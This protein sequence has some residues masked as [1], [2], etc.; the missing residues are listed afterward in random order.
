MNS[1]HILFKILWN[2]HLSNRKNLKNTLELLSQIK[3]DSIFKEFY[4]FHSIKSTQDLALKIIKRKK[5]ISPTVIISN[6]QTN[7]RGRK[8]AKWVSPEGGIWTSLIFETHLKT[9]QSFIFIM[10]SAICIC[11]S[12]ENNTGL[13]A[14][15]KWPND[16]FVN[17]KKIAGIL[18]N[19]ETNMND[20]CNQVIIGIGIN[21]NN[22]IDFLPNILDSHIHYQIT[23]LKKELDNKIISNMKL[24]SEIIN[25]L[26]INLIDTQDPINSTKIFNK[27]KNRIIQSKNNLNYVFNYNNNTVNGELI[28]VNTDGTLLVRDHLQQKNIIISSVNEVELK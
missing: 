7:G 8:G 21:T 13:K 24:L 5:K 6:I 1:I 20:L 15:L 16:I 4:I 18:L 28:D 26:E 9:E 3:K 23:S 12:I 25:K 19:I 2:I 27:Y 10:I 17:G 14:D 22:N 11:E